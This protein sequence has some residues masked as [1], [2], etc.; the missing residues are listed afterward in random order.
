MFSI[1]LRVKAKVK[2]KKTGWC[3]WSYGTWLWYL[4][5]DYGYPITSLTLFPLLPTSPSPWLFHP[6]WPFTVTFNSLVTLLLSHYT[7]YSLPEMFSLQ[8]SSRRT[9]VSFKSLLKMLYL[10]CNTLATI[11]N[12]P[13]L[14]I[15]S[16]GT[17]MQLI[18]YTTYLFKLCL[19]QYNV[20]YMRVEN[21]VC[22][23][24]VL[25]EKFVWAFP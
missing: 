24:T 9:A 4:L 2:F 23:N 21:L 8:T 1:W 12:P 20:S 17:T 7:C 10:E 18:I 5:C 13:H 16:F 19:F 15:F 3:I 14:V 25:A 11:S 22:F 6:H